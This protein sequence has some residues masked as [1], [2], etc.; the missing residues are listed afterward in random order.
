MESNIWQLSVLCKYNH[1]VLFW[2]LLFILEALGWTL[3]NI[4]L[5]FLNIDIDTTFIVENLY[6]KSFHTLG[7]YLL[8]RR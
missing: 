3:N 2:L 7:I 1:G 6:Y 5:K 4:N 8:T